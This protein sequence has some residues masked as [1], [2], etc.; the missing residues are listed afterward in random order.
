MIIYTQEI[1]ES[2]LSLCSGTEVHFAGCP[3]RFICGLSASQ[4]EG[5]PEER[6]GQGKHPEQSAML[7]VRIVSH[8]DSHPPQL[9]PA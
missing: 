2:P 7:I 5:V 4:D 1:N 8:G 9:G 3:A 6:G